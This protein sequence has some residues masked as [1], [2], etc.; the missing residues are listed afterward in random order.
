MN[1]Y[2][3]L[4]LSPRGMIGRRTYWHGVIVIVF[5]NCVLILG[6]SAF[7]TAS[8]QP[9]T[10]ICLAGFPTLW[11]SICVTAK[12]LRGVGASP[13]LQAPIRVAVAAGLI[14]EA[15]GVSTAA[16]GNEG[17]MFA[18]MFGLGL[19]GLIADLVLLL[20]LGVLTPAQ[21]AASM[22]EVFE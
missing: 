21:P 3:R 1:A 12:R 4:F 6:S 20:W 9:V 5:I 22:H 15:L 8:P 7:A 10:R 17:L 19:F 16:T 14:G 11:L 2:L 13:W 18:L